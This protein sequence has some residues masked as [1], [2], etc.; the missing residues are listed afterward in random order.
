MNYQIAG[1]Y[2]TNVGLVHAAKV[3]SFVMPLFVPGIHQNKE[4]VMM[5]KKEYVIILDDGTEVPV[6]KEV[7]SAYMRPKW[8]EEKRQ[9]RERQYDEKLK[10]TR[11]VSLDK[12]I[13]SGGEIHIKQDVK[14]IEE[15]AQDTMM[16]ELLE[17]GL[18]SLDKEE[19]HIINY[20]FYQGISEREYERKFN[21]ARKTVA[22]KKDKILN[23][24][25][26]VLEGFAH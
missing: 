6:T 18:S 2:G 7:Y 4:M 15:I 5:E 19:R 25:K 16:L 21:V 13:D 10:G 24:L 1:A 23:K 14:S 3:A 17:K 26:K 22:Y 9:Q 8:R 20:I 11:I 12:I